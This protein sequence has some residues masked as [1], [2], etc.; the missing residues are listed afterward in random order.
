VTDLTTEELIGAATDIPVHRGFP[1]VD[2]LIDQVREIAREHPECATVR[3][4][5]SS[6]LGEPLL[7]LVIGDGPS[8]AIVFG[9]VHPNEPVGGLTALHLATTLT[10]RA[11]LRESA[12]YT[13]H[14]IACIDPDGMRLNE[15]WFAGPFSRGHYGREF[16]RPAPN[17]QVEWTF[18][19][20]YKRAYFDR[21]LPET[22]ALMRLIDDTRP[23][24]MCSLHNSEF[25]GVYYYLSR[26]MPDELYRSLH[27]VPD[28]LGLDLDIGEPE[29]P[30]ARRFAP[31]VFE[32]IDSRA[33][34]DFVE[35]AG[36]DPTERTAGSSSAAYASKYGTLTLVSEVPY[37]TH[38]DVANVEPS[39]DPYAEALAARADGLRDL[40][41][42]LGACLSAV[43][44]DLST[45]SPFRRASEAFVPSMGRLAAQD[46]HRSAAPDSD[47]PAT[48]AER[49]GCADLVHCFRL[50]YGGMLLRA[51]DAEIAIGNGTPTIRSE[52]AAL[53]DVYD[54]WVDAAEATTP[55]EPIP[56]D[57]LVGVQYAAILAAARFAR[58]PEG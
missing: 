6:R 54:A 29:S 22:V 3:R 56:F 41:R 42:V 55:D 43:E 48:V 39:D 31:A 14:I 58:G 46:Q 2:G 36:L 50:R 30:I 35:E 15:G 12:G 32:M 16:Y 11:D 37:W 26:E 8:Q 10:Q 49:F 33:E 18:P 13:W 38:P 1:P 52:R 21:M 4:I 9:G 34:Y 5:G 40:H 27:V 51:L 47:R 24:F 7:D 57:K 17:E 20:E 28:A 19:F 53:A 44:S 45:P 25:G 23:T